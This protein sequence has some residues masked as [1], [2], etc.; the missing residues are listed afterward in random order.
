MSKTSTNTKGNYRKGETYHSNCSYCTD[1]YLTE[2]RYTPTSRTEGKINVV[3]ANKITRFK[4]D[5]S[6]S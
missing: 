2:S 3:V 6:T 4:G 5:K 1:V